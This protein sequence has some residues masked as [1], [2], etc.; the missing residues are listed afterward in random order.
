MAKEVEHVGETVLTAAI[1]YQKLYIWGLDNNSTYLVEEM[2]TEH[3]K[4]SILLLSTLE[5]A[6]LKG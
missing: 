3:A 5:V 2:L 6:S 4:S 1:E